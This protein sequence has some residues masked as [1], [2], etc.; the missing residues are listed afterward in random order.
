MKQNWPIIKE[1]ACDFSLDQS[2]HARILFEQIKSIDKLFL[3]AKNRSPFSDV[4]S[5]KYTEMESVTCSVQNGK[6]IF[7]VVGSTLL[8]PPSGHLLGNVQCAA[9]YN[10][11]QFFILDTARNGFHLSVLEASY[12][13]ERRPILCK[14]K[15]FVY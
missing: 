9:N 7:V 11:D 10:E 13:K 2:Q 8:A 3:F 15:E 1:I 12:I 14:Q 6:L 5:F 4:A